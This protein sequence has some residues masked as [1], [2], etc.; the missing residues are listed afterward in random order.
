MVS[1]IY[2]KQEWNL[3]LWFEPNGYE[4]NTFTENNEINIKYTSKLIGY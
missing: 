3:K 2:R 4:I 1:K